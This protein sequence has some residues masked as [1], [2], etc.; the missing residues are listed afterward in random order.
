[1]ASSSHFPPVIAIP[2]EPFL[3]IFRLNESLS[4][5]RWPS[6]SGASNDSSNHHLVYSLVH[7]HPSFSSWKVLGEQTILNQMTVP[8][9]PFP[10]ELRLLAV[11][12][13]GLARVLSIPSE[14]QHNGKK[15]ED[16]WHLRLNSLVH[17]KFLVV[18]EVRW[19]FPTELN[20]VSTRLGN[21]HHPKW[22]KGSKSEEL[23]EAESRA[24]L[25]DNS[26]GDKKSILGDEAQDDK[27]E[28]LNF[29]LTWEV[30]GGL[31]RGHLVT[32]MNMVT[33]SLWPDTNY[34]LQV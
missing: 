16:P 10:S 13:H 9:V 20:Q 11:S 24:S 15:E 6:Q 3:S 12:S 2:V 34:I 28:K 19:D 8:S 5:I 7:P 22:A 4:L 27:G 18:T 21:G 1:M 32:E 29:L 33:I 26:N 30:Y 23:K 14:R 25:D 17:Q 31:V